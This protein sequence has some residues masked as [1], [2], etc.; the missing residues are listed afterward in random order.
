MWNHS[1]L[2]IKP[3]SSALAGGSLSTLPSRKSPSVSSLNHDT[4]HYPEAS[5]VTTSLWA[6]YCPC[7]FFVLWLI[8]FFVFCLGWC[9]LLA[10][11]C[12]IFTLFHVPWFRIVHVI[13]VQE[14]RHTY[15]E[16]V[17]CLS[18]TKSICK[19]CIIGSELL[20][21]VMQYWLH[22]NDLL[23][24][25]NNLDHTNNKAILWGL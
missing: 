25:I 19:Y 6:P 3:M 24:E 18:N 23:L 16:F 21:M 2:G 17:K 15:E 14:P 8:L 12:F 9:Y 13:K 4:Q 5:R 1:G 11:G 22:S 7:V 10:L 20:G